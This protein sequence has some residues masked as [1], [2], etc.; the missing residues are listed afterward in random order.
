MSIKDELG[1]E[2]KI[3]AL[4]KNEIYNFKL[5]YKQKHDTYDAY[6]CDYCYL[7]FAI[8]SSKY[9]SMDNYDTIVIW[10]IQ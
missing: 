1:F 9:K 7:M 2:L 8:Y 6:L 3:T 5:H 10:K 4:Q